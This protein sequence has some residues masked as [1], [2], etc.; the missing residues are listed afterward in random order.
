M[1]VSEFFA[2]TQGSRQI[3]F[4]ET[5]KPLCGRDFWAKYRNKPEWESEI[6]HVRLV[7]QRAEQNGLWFDGVL[8]LINLKNNENS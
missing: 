6:D 1:K 8:C 2:V 4:S 5:E 3:A 7:A